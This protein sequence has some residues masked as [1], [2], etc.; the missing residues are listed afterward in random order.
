[1]KLREA[2]YSVMLYEG[3]QPGERTDMDEMRFLDQLDNWMESIGI[4][5]ERA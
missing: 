2:G 5:P 4:R 3:S 1:M